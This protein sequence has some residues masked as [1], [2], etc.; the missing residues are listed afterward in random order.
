M[1]VVKRLLGIYDRLGL[2]NVRLISSMLQS[3][4]ALIADPLAKVKRIEFPPG[5][6]R[7]YKGLMLLERFERTTVEVV[8]DVL[9]PGMNVIDVGAHIGYF[10]LIFSNLV[11]PNGKVYAFEPH[12]D[13]YRLLCKNV[14]TTRH[15]NVIPINKA[16]SDTIGK[17]KLFESAFSDW[18]TLYPGVVK[19]ATGNYPSRSISVESITLD[20]FVADQGNPEF[21]LSR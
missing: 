17:V 21:T 7:Y 9:L 16:V 8:K 2:R 6:N 14:Q 12:P 5:Y 11:G 18:H 1:K 19:E 3:G 13:N 20:A 10:S 15:R 4:L